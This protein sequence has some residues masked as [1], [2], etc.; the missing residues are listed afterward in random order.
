MLT[1]LGIAKQFY[2]GEDWC[3]R[4]VKL[5]T[6]TEILVFFSVRRLVL[7]THKSVVKYTEFIYW[8]M[9][10]ILPLVIKMIK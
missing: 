5:R 6:F 8:V 4:F 3:S 2:I 10:T 1:A 7:E 9:T